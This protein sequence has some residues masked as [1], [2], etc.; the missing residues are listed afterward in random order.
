MVSTQAPP[1]GGIQRIELVGIE[2]RDGGQ[3][4]IAFAEYVRFHRGLLRWAV[5]AL[6][7]VRFDDAYAGFAASQ[8]APAGQRRSVA[9][10]TTR[11]F[12]GIAGFRTRARKQDPKCSAGRDRSRLA[13]IS[14]GRTRVVLANSTRSMPCSALGLGTQ[15]EIA[16]RTGAERGI[17]RISAAPAALA[18]RPTCTGRSRS[19]RANAAWGTGRHGSWCPPQ[20]TASHVQKSSLP[21]R[22]RGRAPD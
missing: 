17:E 19:M 20:M 8:H 2:Q 7:G 4:A 6:K 13:S 14:D 9:G 15:V 11:Y 21:V 5:G 22:V 12:F 16:L 10:V 18:K 1:H 3:G